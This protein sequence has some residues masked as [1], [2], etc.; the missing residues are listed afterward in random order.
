MFNPK[1]LWSR[2]SALF[3]WDSVSGLM[4]EVLAMMRSQYAISTKS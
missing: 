1:S 3:M 4:L 2:P